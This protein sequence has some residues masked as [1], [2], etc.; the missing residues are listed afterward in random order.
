M[1][2]LSLIRLIKN[3]TPLFLKENLEKIK[4][5]QDPLINNGL[6][7]NYLKLAPQDGIVLL[8]RNTLITNSPFTNG[9][10]FRMYNYSGIQERTG[11][12]SYLSSFPGSDEIVLN[13]TDDDSE[14]T[15][16]AG[17][18]KINLTKKRQASLF[19]FSLLTRILRIL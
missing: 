1:E 4:G 12:F 11:F 9:Y 18:G 19:F 7:I 2:A 16:S 5:E 6:R 10:F 8:K 15:V 3:R 17:T 14:L 13:S